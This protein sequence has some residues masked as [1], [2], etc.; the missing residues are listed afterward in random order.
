M[1]RADPPAAVLPL[2]TPAAVDAGLAA[3]VA[4][5]DGVAAVVV[6]YQVDTAALGELLKDLLGQVGAVVLVDNGSPAWRDPPAL[7]LPVQTLRLPDNRGLAAA[8]NLGLATALASGAREVLL[9]DQDSR[10]APGMV[11]SLRAAAAAAA[12]TG[13]RVAAAGPLV[14]DE[15]GASEGFVRFG[16]GRYEAVLP[17]PGERWLPCDMLI[18]SGTLLQAGAL[19]AIGGMDE[20]LFIDKVDTDWSLRAAAHGYALIGAP[21]ARLH[22]RLGEQWVSLWP[23]GWRRLRQHR[24]FRYYYMVRNGIRLRRQPHAHAAWR[25]ADGRQLLSLVLYFG[26][27]APGRVRALAMMARGWWHGLRG[28]GGPMR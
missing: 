24:A 17:Q 23:G 8:Q 11:A 2:P 1:S 16:R 26:L 25:R 14:V 18:A 20:A 5:Y 22:H 28:V 19:A 21:E 10:P 3:A 9:L 15:A 12:A 6:T 4:A 13:L 27:L 7:P